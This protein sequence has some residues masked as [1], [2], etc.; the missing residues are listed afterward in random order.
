MNTQPI[1]DEIEE[2]HVV[3]LTQR[4]ADMGTLDVA[5]ELSRLGRVDTAV[6]FRVLP[7]ARALEVFEALEPTDQQQVIDGLQDDRVLDLIEGLDPDDRVR[8]FDELPAKIVARLLAQL[9]PN[10]RQLTGLLMGYPEESVGRHMSPEYVSLRASM[11]VEDALIRIR[12]EGVDAETIYALPVVDDNRYLIGVAGLRSIILA[13]PSTLIVDVMR[14]D[15]HMVHT[16][17]DREDAARLVRSAGLIALPVVDSEGRLVGVLTVDDAM[18]ILEVE[19][20]EDL[21]LQGGQT[22]LNKPYLTVSA[23]RIARSRGLW[24][25]ILIVA[26]ALTV[27]V[28]QTFEGTLEQAVTLA[29]FIPLLIGTGG[30]SGAQA[31]TA[32]IRAMA[33]GEVRFADL[34]R[35]VWRE[36]RVGVVLGVILAVAVF[37]PVAYIYEP[38][39]AFVVALTLVTICTWATILGSALPLLAKR[40]K[41][42]PAVVSA[43]AITT[44]VDATGL[45][46]YFSFAIVILGL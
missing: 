17:V 21:A 16:D 23:V 1:D 10:E 28:L 44:L 29:L 6:A 8:L 4:L 12:R 31:S 22:P 34:P 27:R 24:L 38:D 20:S 41:I 43:P 9:S 2:E 18:E 35:V 33:L 5:A 45:I 32:V 46:I 7:R 37:V 42:D 15:V 36:A 30:N 26:A 39:I 13:S 3:E 11:T 25:L 40:L 14:T 19:E